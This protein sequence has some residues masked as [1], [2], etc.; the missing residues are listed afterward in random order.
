MGQP[1]GSRAFR[2]GAF[3]ESVAQ[4]FIAVIE[5]RIAEGLALQDTLPNRAR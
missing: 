3:E 2:A 5:A 4:R 1:G